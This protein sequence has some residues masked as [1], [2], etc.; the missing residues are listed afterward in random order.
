MASPSSARTNVS[1]A[2]DA[3]CGRARAAS[4]S[5]ANARGRS[6]FLIIFASTSR[7]IS[8]KAGYGQPPPARPGS[9][10]R[11]RP[12]FFLDVL[13]KHSQHTHPA[14]MAD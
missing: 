7:A 4:V 10:P 8:G 1:L 9:T 2:D 14:S 13:S 3:G 11:R 6:V 5:I 12:S